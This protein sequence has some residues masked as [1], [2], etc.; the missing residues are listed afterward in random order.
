MTTSQATKI[1]GRALSAL[2]IAGGERAVALRAAAL[3]LVT[4]ATHGLGANAAD[5]LFFF[6]FGVEEL[7]RMIS[8]AGVGV[9]V[10]VF[11]HTV[12]LTAMGER[13]WLPIVTGA[14]A[15]WVFVS[16]AGVFT[17]SPIIYPVI[18]ISTQGIIMV[19]FT[20]MWNAAGAICTTRQAKRLFPIFAAAG[21]MGG[22]LGN[23]A[24]GPIAALFGAQS[25]LLVQGSLLVVSFVLLLRVRGLMRDD[26][27]PEE[28]SASVVARVRGSISAIRSSRLL[29]LASAV[30]F[31]TWILFYLVVFPFSE[32]VAASFDTEA[33][34][35]SFLG[36]FSSVATT[37]TFLVGLFVAKRLFA[38]LGLVLSLLI[39]P[40]VY[41]AGFGLWLADFDL[42]TAALVR[43]AQWVAL[44]AIGATAFTAL[45]NVVTGRRRAEVVAFM[46]AVPAQLGVIAGGILLIASDTISRTS[47]FVIGLAVSLAAVVVV[48]AMRP[49]Y[50]DAIV[51]SVRRGLTGVFDV[52]GP[53]L[54]SP[55]DAEATRILEE[56]LSDE[57]PAARAY[58]ISALARLHGPDVVERAEAYLGDDSPRVRAT[59]FDIICEWDTEGFSEHA[60]A[61]LTDE[62]PDLRIRALHYAASNDALNAVKAALD[63]PDLRVRATAAVILGGQEGRAVALEVLRSGDLR[64]KRTLLGELARSDGRLNL[65][66]E[67]SLVDDDPEVRALAARVSAG[68]GVAPHRIRPLLDDSSQRVRRAAADSLATTNEGRGLLLEVLQGGTVNET[69]AALRALVPLQELTEDFVEWARNEA[70]R[71]ARLERAFVALNV[72]ETSETVD[73]LRR[74]L[75]GRTERLEQWVL[76]AMTTVDTQEVMPIVRKGVAAADPETRSQAI[77]ALEELGD[78]RVLSVL[79]PLLD[80]PSDAPKLDEREALRQL[81]TDFDQWLRALALRCLADVIRFDL[82]HVYRVAQSDE[83][84]L[85]R[86]IV[87]S[88]GPM[89]LEKSDTLGTL[90]RVLA[91]QRVPMFSDLDPEDLEILARST[92]EI[93]YEPGE[94]I[95]SQGVRG[96]EALMIVDGS[97]IVSVTRD[98]QTRVV[99]QY[100]PGDSVGE[101]ALLGSGE[102]SADVDA[103]EDGLH[104]ILITKNDFISILEERPSVA[105]GMLST[106]AERIAEET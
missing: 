26:E 82:D 36:V 79:L 31:T 102:R 4:Q 7:P 53:G 103:G 81:S 28:A 67:M 10:L 98:G 76:L 9:M 83:S 1:G 54:L 92:E 59:A 42:T 34:V 57:R 14:S 41:L 3:F 71:A 85:V 18:W 8:L 75:R 60:A 73:F 84:D 29:R 63:D 33:E 87:P 70:E 46:T 88:L 5:T 50:V 99:N 90:D 37:A 55:I 47:Q 86:D 95:F 58:A 20:M 101:L 91:L 44:N 68:L 45:F 11:G 6:R 30:A 80:Q 96:T 19:T 105:L 25:L 16:W 24:T 48:V 21:V 74:V 39:L 13:R 17:E 93:A 77:E 78:R 69:D 72:S 62:T 89:P 66:P 12:G 65:D 104:G 15:V 23:L 51:S 22:I 38:R 100:G 40:V 64:A 43:G 56:H 27:T 49:A 94:R 52:P 61:A 32:S 2:G 35:A 97:A 106:L